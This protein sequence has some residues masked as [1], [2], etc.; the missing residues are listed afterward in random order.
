MFCLNV[1]VIVYDYN[2]KILM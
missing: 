2:H 1:Y